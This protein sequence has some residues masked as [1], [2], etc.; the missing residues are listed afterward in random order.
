MILIV[1]PLARS[2]PPAPEYELLYAEEFEGDRV[3]ER[4]WSFRTGPRTGTGINGL[5]LAR[6]VRVADSHLIVVAKHEFVDGQPA[7]HR[8]VVA[9]AGYRPDVATR[10]T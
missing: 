6:H 4:D 7:H 10:V 3:N 8:D 5:N 2:D 1:A 9:P